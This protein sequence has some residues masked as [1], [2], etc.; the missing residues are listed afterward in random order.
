MFKT[1]HFFFFL[2]GTFSSPGSSGNTLE[3]T[4]AAIVLPPSLKANLI[5]S[6]TGKGKFNFNLAYTLSPGIPILLSFN[7]CTVTAT[8]AVLK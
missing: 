6:T 7:K 4:P 3:T 8:S 1:Y 5:P 2:S